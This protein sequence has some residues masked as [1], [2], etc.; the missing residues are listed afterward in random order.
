VT[1]EGEQA[2]KTIGNVKEVEARDVPVIAVTDGVSDVERDADYTLSIP[3]TNPRTAP[4][5]ERATPTRELPY[6]ESCCLSNVSSGEPHDLATS[7][8][9][10]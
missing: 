5:F 7:T 2:R 10:Y 8:F 1:G 3:E 4:I 6:S 9:K